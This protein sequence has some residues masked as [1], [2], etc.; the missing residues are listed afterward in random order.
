[1]AAATIRCNVESGGR[2]GDELS[3]YI[4]ASSSS[5]SSND[6]M[7]YV[8]LRRIHHAPL[9]S[10]FHGYFVSIA[11]ALPFLTAVDITNC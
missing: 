3:H 10:Q 4:S 2:T 9:T 6:V 5:R 11:A 8:P 7:V 1:M